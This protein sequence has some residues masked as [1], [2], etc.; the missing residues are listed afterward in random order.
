M[1]SREGVLPLEAARDQRRHFFRH[2]AAAGLGAF[3]DAV[4][5]GWR[6]PN[7]DHRIFR[8]TRPITRAAFFDFFIPVLPRAVLCH[9]IITER[10]D[11][12]QHSGALFAVLVMIP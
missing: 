9:G 2:A 12:S 8:P 1:R 10:L 3:G 11:T 6:Y 4:M 5:Q 7:R